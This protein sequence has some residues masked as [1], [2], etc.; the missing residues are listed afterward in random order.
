MA[1]EL[2]GIDVSD[3]PELL[4]LA[5]E[6]RATGTPRVLRRNHEDIA[7]VTPLETPRGRRRRALAAKGEA[8]REA[9]L[10]SF[11]GWKGIVD[12]EKLKAD[13]RESRRISTRPRVE[14]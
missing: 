9:F 1:R 4:R 3:S 7:V 14:L 11:G 10:S 8:D 13:I 5:E 2:A 12:P 6:V